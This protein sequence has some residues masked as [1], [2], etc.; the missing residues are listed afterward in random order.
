VRQ[1][2]ST[3]PEAFAVVGSEIDREFCRRTFW[4]RATYHVRVNRSEG[5]PP[6]GLEFSDLP[7]GAKDLRFPPISNEDV[8]EAW[9]KAQADL[10]SGIPLPREEN[11]FQLKFPP[12]PK[13]MADLHPDGWDA[14]HREM[15]RRAI[16]GDWFL[17][18]PNARKFLSLR[19]RGSWAL[20]ETQNSVRRA[21][22]NLPSVLDAQK[23]VLLFWAMTDPDVEKAEQTL[24][25]FQHWRRQDI[26]LAPAS[27]GFQY[28]TL[29][30]S[31]GWTPTEL[32]RNVWNRDEDEEPS[33]E[34]LSVHE[35][36]QRSLTS[37]R[38]VQAYNEILSRQPFQGGRVRP[39]SART[40]RNPISSDTI[41]ARRNHIEAK[42][43]NSAREYEL[44]PH[45]KNGEPLTA[46]SIS[47]WKKDERIWPQ[48]SPKT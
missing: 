21:I 3:F 30:T 27:G 33:K 38:S 36:L 9:E 48:Q 25:E 15:G 45:G 41:L 12:L 6:H 28:P 14:V 44:R 13:N 31:K 23:F 47:R 8:D 5:G 10:A 29:N 1:L 35:S 46:G 39:T 16:V 19:A 7:A 2:I 42:L 37:L 4:G 34:V 24:T 32:F 11:P 26:G 20:T 17:P 18:D 40:G 43:A 22:I